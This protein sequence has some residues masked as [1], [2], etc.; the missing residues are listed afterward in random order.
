MFLRK[1]KHNEFIITD[2][3]K[4]IKKGDYYLDMYTGKPEIHKCMVYAS[5]YD[6]EYDEYISEYCSK[7]THSFPQI[8]GTEELN[9]YEIK[10]LIGEYDES[11]F[12]RMAVEYVSELIASD[13]YNPLYNTDTIIIAKSAYYSAL[14]RMDEHIQKQKKA[15]T[16]ADMMQFAWKNNTLPYRLPSTST[17]AEWKKNAEKCIEY[18]INHKGEWEVYFNDEGKLEIL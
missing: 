4:P 16:H 12:G 10:I 18:E 13:V 7:I 2:K 15:Y 11:I 14:M 6:I 1:I 9:M 17:Y 5:G 8:A 3:D